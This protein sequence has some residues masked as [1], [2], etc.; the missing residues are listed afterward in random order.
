MCFFW[1]Q[2]RNDSFDER[3][4]EGKCSLW[5]PE[6]VVG[7]GGTKGKAKKKWETNVFA[8]EMKIKRK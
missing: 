2:R 3:D 4:E 1:I 6:G 5:T 8:A 7:G